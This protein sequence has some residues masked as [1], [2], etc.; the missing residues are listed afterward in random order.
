VMEA[1]LRL[2]H[3]FMPFLTEELWTRLPQ[4]SA[5]DGAPASISLQPFPEAAA[6]WRE[7]EA[8]QQM[9]QLQEII[10]AARNLR[11]EMK[12]DPKRKVAAELAP[13][14]AIPRSLL[15]RHSNALLRLA[16]LNALLMADGGRR[17][18][19]SKGAVRT[20][21]EFELLI[22][23]DEAVDRGAEIEKIRREIAR[24]EKDIQAK[25]ARLA[26]EAFRSKAPPDVVRT[27]EQALGDRRAEFER[28][29]T[30]LSQHES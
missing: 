11:A 30:R 14:A 12:L 22:P 15:E 27:M 28:L 10:A 19:P 17:L 5:A 20:T 29:R 8:E 2:L 23:F 4:A 3:P 7:L 18:D 26:D 13:T 9:A 24:L 1:A 16:N 6:D 25:T 21:A